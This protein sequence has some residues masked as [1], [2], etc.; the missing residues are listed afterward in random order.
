[1]TYSATPRVELLLDDPFNLPSGEIELAGDRGPDHRDLSILPGSGELHGACLVGIGRGGQD[2]GHLVGGIDVEVQ[3]SLHGASP[4]SAPGRLRA[5][6][7]P[8]GCCSRS[9][10]TGL[11]P[12]P[13]RPRCAGG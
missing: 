12:G 1:M 9:A 7:T 13:S 11:P 3:L 2:A 4:R 10:M 8:P 6:A 5:A